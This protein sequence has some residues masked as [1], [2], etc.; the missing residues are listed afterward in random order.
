MQNLVTTLSFLHSLGIVHRD[1]KPENI[2]CKKGSDTDIKITDFGLSNIMPAS[3]LLRSKCGTPVYMAPEMLQNRPYDES[4][5]IWAAGILLYIILSGTLPFYAD[6]PDDFLELVLNS[7]FSF[8]DS[9]WANVSEAAKDLIRKILVPD[10][11]RR[12]SSSQILAHPWMVA[13][14]Q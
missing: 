4:V 6:N 10:P 9:E 2:L 5:D 8:P 1:L 12:L 13:N 7:S 14:T 11:K 3:A